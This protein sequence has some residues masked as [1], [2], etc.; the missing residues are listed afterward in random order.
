MS[1]DKTR[2][3]Q[4]EQPDLN[5]MFSRI[6]I[7]KYLEHIPLGYRSERDHVVTEQLIVR[8][9]KHFIELDKKWEDTSGDD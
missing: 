7:I 6:Q 5:D 4:K 3:P 1:I 9:Q 2:W 8:I